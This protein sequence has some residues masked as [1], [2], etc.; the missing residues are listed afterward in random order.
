MSNRQWAWTYVILCVLGILLAIAFIVLKIYAVVAYGD[1]P[2]QEC[3]T[4]V[5]WILS[6]K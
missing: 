4:W 3:P 1:L 5:V 2:L 6:D